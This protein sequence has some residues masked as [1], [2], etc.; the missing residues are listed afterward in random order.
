MG[1]EADQLGHPINAADS[2]QRLASRDADPFEQ[3]L[4]GVLLV[5]E[6]ADEAEELKFDTAADL[7]V[8]WCQRG[9]DHAGPRMLAAQAV[10]EL[11]L[12]GGHGAGWIGLEASAMRTVRR[13]LLG[14][15]GL[16]RD[17]LY[18]RGY[19]KIGVADHPDHDTGED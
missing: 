2:T 19:W 18:T 11:D 9:A 12:P 5:A 1:T 7:S 8:S 17:Q 13:H 10:R 14:E 15:R 16:D 3:A 4:E 6:V